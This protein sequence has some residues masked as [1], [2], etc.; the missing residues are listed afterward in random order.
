MAVDSCHPSFAGADEILDDLSLKME[1]QIDQNLGIIYFFLE[2]ILGILCSNKQDRV[3]KG[4]NEQLEGVEHKNSFC[5]SKSYFVTS[6]TITHNAIKHTHFSF[7]LEHSPGDAGRVEPRISA[8][9]P[10]WA[11][12]QIP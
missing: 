2:W 8:R 3:L 11:P 9:S 7:M 4:R 6:S 12:R 5:Y 1:E 10:V